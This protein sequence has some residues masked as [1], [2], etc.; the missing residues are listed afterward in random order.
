MLH[1]YTVLYGRSLEIKSIDLYKLT[2]CLNKQNNNQHDNYN[3][4]KEKKNNYDKQNNHITKQSHLK[5]G[6]FCQ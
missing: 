3:Q 1:V 2:P 5:N 6:L 4:K